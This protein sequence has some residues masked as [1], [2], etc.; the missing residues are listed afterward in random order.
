MKHV[1]KSSLFVASA[2]MMLLVQHAAAQLSPT[3]LGSWGTGLYRSSDPRSAEILAYDAPSRRLFVV[4]SVSNN[5]LILDFSNPALPRLIDSVRFTTGSPNSIDIRNGV[6]AV[7]VDSTNRQ[8]PGRVFFYRAA[9]AG[10]TATALASVQVGALPDMLTFTADGRFVLVANEGEPNNYNAGNIDPEGS[11]SIIEIPS[12]GAQAITQANVRTVDFRS[13]NGQETALRARGVRIFGPRATVAQDLEP[14]YITVQGDTA[15]VVCQENN[16]IALVRISTAS[17]IGIR[18]LGLK[19]HNLAGFGLDPSDRDGAGGTGAINIAPRPV[20]GIYQPDGIASYVVGGQTF[21]VT[22]N[23]GDAR[24]GYAGTNEPE[25][26]GGAASVRLDP[27]VFG[28][29]S[30]TTGI[31]R[32][33]LLGRLQ[34]SI[35]LPDTTPA[36]LYRSL[37]CFGGR[38]FSIF[39]VERDSL[40]RVYDSGDD[41][42]RITAARFP[43]N[44]NATN[45]SNA[46][47]NRSDDKGPEP[48]D[49]KIARIGDSTYA[50]IG[51]ER[52]GGVMIYNITSPTAPRFVAYINNRNFSV[53]PGASTVLSGAV[54][55]PVAADRVGDL[56]AE[57]LLIIPGNLSP[58]S[59][60]LLVVANEVSGTVTTIQLSATASV[61]QLAEVMPKGFALEQ[62]YPNPFNPTTTIRYSLPQAAQVSLKVYDILG[63]EVAQ[64]VNM[65]QAAGVYVAQFNAANLPS[66]MYF[67]RLEAGSYRE[68][69]KMM[70]VK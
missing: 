47:D 59:R 56:G 20:F 57:G 69:R 66:G 21:V 52:I 68:T 29:T 11:V 45:T 18:G 42:E 54:A 48:E 28:D 27:A 50:F 51:L 22:A 55:G 30:R 19:N 39:R 46:L 37:Q 17:L 70:L 49:V 36:G 64:L 34:I 5:V 1:F 24:D 13:L 4:N 58:N 6:L 67:Y 38:S 53:T 9:T 44:F 43:A 23:E 33:S 8:A 26:R 32:D 35:A 63:R 7:A 15:Y 3:V 10:A 40:V 62:N 12:A 16:A 25:I 14:E 60:P 61:E 31:R 41:F 65:R 2:L